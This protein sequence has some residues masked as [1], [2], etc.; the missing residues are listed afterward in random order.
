MRV[1]YENERFVAKQVEAQYK[2]ECKTACKAVI[3]FSNFDEPLKKFREERL[4]EIQ[5]LMTNITISQLHEYYKSG[6]LLVSDV[7]YYYVDRIEK[8]DMDK[9]NSVICLNPELNEI[10][11]TYDQGKIVGALWGVPL[12]L[13]DNICTKDNMP[14]TAGAFVFKNMI[15][16]KDAFIVQKLRAAGAII[17]GKTNL[18]EWANFMTNESTNGYSGIGGQTKNPYGLYDVGGSSSGSA[19]AVAANFCM[20]ALGTETAGSIVYPAS[21][22]SVIGIKPSLGLVSRSG[23]I[24]ITMAQDTAGVMANSIEDVRLVLNEIAGKDEEDYETVIAENV[25][26]EVKELNHLDKIKIAVIDLD[27]PRAE[28]DDIQMRVAKEFRELGAETKYMH[29]NKHLSSNIDMETVL[30]YGFRTEI[31]QMIGILKV[32]NISSLKDIIDF[33]G[34]DI[35]NRAP[36]GQS[37]L[38]E[39]EKLTCSQE[40]WQHLV[41]ENKKYA[42]EAL[43]EYLDGYDCILS[44]SN[45]LSHLYPAAG[46]PA[47]TFPVGYKSTG[48]P[49]GATLVGKRLTE[50]KLF[51]IAACYMAHYKY[52]QEPLPHL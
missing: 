40:E 48:E 6:Q 30:K 46:Y 32:E 51:Q 44:L 39:S 29:I 49:I 12:L 9:L 22:N 37:I 11:E 13:K 25:Q 33:N 16:E 43:D 36:K 28:E 35:E 42:K 14:T 38:E 45:Y 1:D 41:S 10:L 26:A 18:S 50:E 24:P 34:L 23:I 17:L 3:D 2:N 47:L 27:F 4:S 20:A 21:Q 5:K 19:V 31:N 8:Y 52:H 15:A 7:V